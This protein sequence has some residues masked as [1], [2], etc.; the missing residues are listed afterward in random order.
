MTGAESKPR[1]L[2]TDSTVTCGHVLFGT[3]SLQSNAKLRVRHSPVLVAANLGPGIGIGEGC[4]KVGDTD[5]PCITTKVPTKGASTKLRAGGL[6][7]MLS[8]L[9]GE[10]N[11]V[12]SGVVGA[13]T[14]T[15]VQSKL[16]AP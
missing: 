4:T 2:T 12:I 8:T 16:V 7:V 6:P 1:V 11:G 15:K 13:L 5:V 10:T 9:I 3:V 14:V